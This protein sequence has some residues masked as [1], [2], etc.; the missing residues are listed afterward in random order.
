MKRQNDMEKSRHVLNT[1]GQCDS[2]SV[3]QVSA[4]TQDAREGGREEGVSKALTPRGAA[5]NRNQRGLT[6]D[7]SAHFKEDIAVENGE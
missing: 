3:E 6:L 1:V 5:S 7:L 2:G 4:H